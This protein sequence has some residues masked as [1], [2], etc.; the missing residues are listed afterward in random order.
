MLK[1]TEIINITSGVGGVVV[2]VIAS[3]PSRSGIIFRQCRR[4]FLRLKISDHVFLRK[5]SKVVGPGPGVCGSLTGRPRLGSVPEIADVKLQPMSKCWLVR[6]KD[7][8][9]KYNC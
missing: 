5:G 8:I 7:K 9:N 2:S 6:K 4:D 1:L 3:H